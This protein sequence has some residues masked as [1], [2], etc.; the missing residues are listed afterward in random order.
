MNPFVLRELPGQHGRL[1]RGECPCG[2]LGVWTQ[3]TK[4]AAAG[5]AQA[6]LLCGEGGGGAAPCLRHVTLGEA[7]EQLTR[8]SEGD[9]VC[10]GRHSH[11][12]M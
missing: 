5:R 12:E 6:L 8:G 1:A 10:D 2:S 4:E 9:V 11:R 3:V 7:A